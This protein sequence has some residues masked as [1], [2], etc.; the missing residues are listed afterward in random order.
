MTLFASKVLYCV[1]ALTP[2]ALLPMSSHL[3][4][5][6]LENDYE[7]TGTIHKNQPQD[8]YESP[9]ATPDTS[10]VRISFWEPAYL[11][12]Y[13]KQTCLEKLAYLFSCCSRAK[14]EDQNS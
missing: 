9:R 10:Q 13:K 12:K 4:Q 2:G 7:Q 8:Y 11:S 6:L 3:S 1:I 14:S 5:P